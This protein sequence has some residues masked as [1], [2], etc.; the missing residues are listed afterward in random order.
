MT[1]RIWDVTHDGTGRRVVPLCMALP[2]Q[3][4]EVARCTLY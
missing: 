3:P 1:E 2:L 4:I